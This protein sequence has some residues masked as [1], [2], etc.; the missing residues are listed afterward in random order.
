[1][2][3]SSRKICGRCSRDSIYD[4]VSGRGQNA[5]M[6]KAI[7]FIAARPLVEPGE[8]VRIALVT[9]CALALILAGPFLPSGL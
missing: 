9:G 5:G 4:L 6:A 2:A 7:A 3:R 8:L 1:M